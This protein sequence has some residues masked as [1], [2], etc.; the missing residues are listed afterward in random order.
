MTAVLEF[1]RASGLFW[2]W[3]ALGV[4]GL[5]QAIR[6]LDKEGTA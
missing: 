2:M 5:G 1:I 4:L 6:E 3:T